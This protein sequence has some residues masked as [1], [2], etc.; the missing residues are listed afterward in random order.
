MK[1]I[2]HARFLHLLVTPLIYEV[3]AKKWCL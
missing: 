3:T 1:P 2:H